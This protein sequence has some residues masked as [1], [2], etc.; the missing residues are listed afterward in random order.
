[1]AQYR[2]KPVVIDAIRFNG[3][4]ENEVADFVGENLHITPDGFI[5]I[6][7][8]E[9]SMAVSYGD[10]VIK[11][12]RGEFYPCKPD[13]FEQTYESVE[14]QKELDEAARE[15]AKTTFKKPYSDNPDE[16]VTIVEPDKYAGF[17]AGAK[18]DREQMMSKAVCY[19]AQPDITATG[20]IVI[21]F[22]RIGYTALSRYGI[23]VGDKVRIIIVKE[24]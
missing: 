15:Y 7:T 8:L 3:T 18:W 10:Y 22:I 12:V 19:I 2:K 17:I 6:H 1:M 21:P 14:S 16:E 9:G 23:K 13:I 5:F 4:N 24:D 11:G 20:N